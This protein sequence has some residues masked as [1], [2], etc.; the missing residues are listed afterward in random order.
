MKKKVPKLT[1]FRLSRELFLET[2]Q[3]VKSVLGLHIRVRIAYE[4]IPKSTQCTPK[5]EKNSNICQVHT[6]LPQQT[7]KV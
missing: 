4:P 6:F 3:K 1:N 7:E 2:M 5:I